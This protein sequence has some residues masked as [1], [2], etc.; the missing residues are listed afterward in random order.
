VNT[1][2]LDHLVVAAATL[3]AGAHWCHQTL[4]IAPGPGGKH[5]LMGT[6]NRVFSIASE[7]FAQA[8]LEII[9]IDPEAP[10]PG[11]ARWFGLDAIDLG[12]GPR[13]IHWAARTSALDDALAALRAHGIDA[14]R[15]LAASRGDLHWRIAVRDDG[16]LPAG[17]AQ[18]TLI[19]W[20]GPHP[21]EAMPASGVTLRSFSADGA[22]L[23]ATLDTPRGAVTLRTTP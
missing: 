5:A 8:Y 3:D 13:L 19:E 22:V 7:R 4:G 21:T 2:A 14:G 15:A 11:R 17:G 16:A 18:P 9:A 23:T 6:H 20:P 12:G 10:P 1:L